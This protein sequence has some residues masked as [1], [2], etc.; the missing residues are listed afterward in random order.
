M[1]KI[2]LAAIPLGT[3]SG[4]VHGSRVGGDVMGAALAEDGT[5]IC[6]HLSSSVEWAQHDMGLTSDWKHEYY[7]EHA[8]DGYELIWVD[9][10]ASHEGW[11]AALKL[12]REKQRAAESA[13]QP[14]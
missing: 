10:V 14:A 4:L 6:E 2:F 7:R 11:Q 5:G 3:G 9:D 8:P 1:M 12:N 13:V